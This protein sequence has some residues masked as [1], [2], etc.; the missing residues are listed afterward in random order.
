M[1]NSLINLHSPSFLEI[2]SVLSLLLT[3]HGDDPSHDHS[4]QFLSILSQANI[5]QHVSFLTHRRHHTLD[6]VITTADSSLSPVI[7]YTPSDHIP[8]I[9]SL[10]ITTPKLSPLSKH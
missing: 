9:S 2:S 5:T 7:T 4:Q 8:V 3:I 6:L 1:L 10:K